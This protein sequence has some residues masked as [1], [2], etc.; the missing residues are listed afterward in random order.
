MQRRVECQQKEVRKYAARGSTPIGG[1]LAP[2]IE[3]TDVLLLF[4]DADELEHHRNAY[5]MVLS[6]EEAKDYKVGKIYTLQIN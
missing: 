2:D 4:Y 1:A 5:Q 3:K 6:V